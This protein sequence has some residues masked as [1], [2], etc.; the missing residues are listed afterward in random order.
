M[1]DV[2]PVVDIAPIN[3]GMGLVVAQTVSDPAGDG[4]GTH[5][6]VE[7]VFIFDTGAECGGNHIKQSADDG[8]ARRQ[9]GYGGCLSGDFPAY[10]C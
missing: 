4:P 3:I 10:F 6:R 7:G 1:N 8:R 2:L 5:H 9:T